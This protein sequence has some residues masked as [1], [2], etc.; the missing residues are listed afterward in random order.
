MKII[1]FLALITLATCELYH[2]QECVRGTTVLLKEPCSSGTYEGN[3]P[4][5]PL[6]DKRKFKNFTLQFF[7]LL[8]Q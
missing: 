5:H 2:Y 1:L 6:A 3:S 7:L 8:R 4:F